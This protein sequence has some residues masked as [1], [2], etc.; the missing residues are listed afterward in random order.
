MILSDFAVR[1]PVIISIL[2]V[3]LLVFGALAFFNLNREMMPPGARHYNLAGGRCRGCGRG[4]HTPD[5]EPAFHT[6]RD[7]HDDFHQ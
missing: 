3:V 1:H 2:V 5:R 6:G 4:D 7:V